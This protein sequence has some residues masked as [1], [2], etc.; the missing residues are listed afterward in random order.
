M[1]Q[2]ALDNASLSFHVRQSGRVTFK[3]FVV[4]QMFRRSKN[5]LFEIKAIDG[6]TFDLAKGTRLGVI[7]RNGAG[8]STLLKLLAGVYPPTSGERRVV[9]RISSLFDLT[10]GFEPEATGWENVAFRGYLQG[11]SPKSLRPKLAGIAE[12]SELG[13]FLNVPVRHYSSGMLM[14][15][16]FAVATAM[17][18]EILLVDEVLSVGDMAFREKARRRMDQLL[19]RAHLFVMVSHDM[20]AIT[21]ICD[22]VL[23]LEKGRM[24]RLGPTA[25]IIAEYKQQSASP[26]PAAPPQAA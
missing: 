10:L 1:A 17:E 9:G 23:W 25:E 12:F 4:R 15:L 19:D 26:A 18:P 3:E 20:D 7:G 6:I 21:K 13:D 5:P 8:K 24:K 11:E 14:R 16:G 22:R 2:I